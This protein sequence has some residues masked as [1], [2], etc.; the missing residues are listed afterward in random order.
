MSRSIFLSLAT[1]G[2]LR[3]LRNRNF[4]IV[5]SAGWFSAAGIWF[6]RIAIQVLTWELTHS[7]VWLGIIAL[8]EAMPVILLSP[9]AGTLAD[10]HDRLVL[11]RIVQFSIMA[12]TAG[13]AGVTLAGWIDIYL[14]LAFALAHGAGGAFWMPVRLAMVP[15][16]VRR[17]DLA[18]AIALHSTLF[19]LARFLGPALAVPV[20]ALWGAGAAFAINTLSYLIY[21]VALFTIELVNPDSR[22]KHGRN[23]M[24]HFKEGFAYA[25]GHPALKYLFLM[26]LFSAVFLRAYMELLPG[27]SETMFSHDAKEGVAILVSAAGLGAIGGSIAIGSMGRLERMLR[28]YFFCLAGSAIFLALFAVSASF[29]VAVACSV[30]LS[31]TTVAINITGQTIVQ[32]TVKGELRGRVMSLW[33]LITRS[34]P[35]LGALLLGWLSGFMGFQWPILAAAAITGVVA[36][37]VIGKRQAIAAGLTAR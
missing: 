33:G 11:A 24:E 6:Y 28:A 35:A 15:N 21:L 37:Y 34:G 3:A 25:V 32:S 18:V 30:F 20:L 29:W 22:A 17:E 36:F 19:N 13:L 14:L 16:L 5:E 1:K 9:I 27:I 8:A 23:M 12:V 4:A 7:G 31:G 10:R 26:I 2:P